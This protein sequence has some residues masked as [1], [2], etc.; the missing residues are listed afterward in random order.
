MPPIKNKDKQ[1]NES[2]KKNVRVAV[3]FPLQRVRG[4]LN[5]L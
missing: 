1:G 5:K 3:E 4:Q 2:K